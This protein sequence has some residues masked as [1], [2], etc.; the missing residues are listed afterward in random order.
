MSD[1]EDEFEPFPDDPAESSS[2]T[3]AEFFPAHRPK[4]HING[5]EESS[6][7][8]LWNKSLKLVESTYELYRLS[9]RDPLATMSLDQKMFPDFTRKIVSWKTF[10]D[11]VEMK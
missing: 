3:T 6:G 7:L 11:E 8:W 2:H 9:K 5:Q 1:D 10:R 4:I